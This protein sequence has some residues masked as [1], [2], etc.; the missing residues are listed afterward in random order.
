MIEELIRQDQE[1]QRAKINTET[2]QISWRELQRFFAA[3]RVRVVDGELDLV[4]VAFAIQQDDIDRV[5]AW[6]AQ[7]KLKVASDDQARRWHDSDA[8][9]WAVVI[10]PWVLVQESNSAGR[11]DESK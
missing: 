5:T 11:E 2:A 1:L 3:G 10:K 7:Q 6:T 4:E 8:S 9:L